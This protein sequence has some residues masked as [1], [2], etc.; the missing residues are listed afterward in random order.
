MFDALGP[1]LASGTVI[2]FDELFNYPTFDRHELLAFHQFI[3]GSAF[4][5]E[6]IGKNGPVDLHPVRDNGYFDQPAALR[7]FQK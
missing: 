4:G 3:V 7:L 6:W 1:H 5:I 2:V